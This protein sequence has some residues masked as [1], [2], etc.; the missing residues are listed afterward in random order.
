M[1]DILRIDWNEIYTQLNKREGKIRVYKLY[2]LINDPIKDVW[3]KLLPV[4][5]SI[6]P[7]KLGNKYSP[8]DTMIH[9]PDKISTPY[10][11]MDKDNFR[12]L[13]KVLYENPRSV[14]LPGKASEHI[15]WSQL[16]PLW[17]AAYKEYKN[18]GYNEWIR[19]DLIKFMVGPMYDEIQKIP[20]NFKFDKS[21]LDAF[22]DA[23]LIFGSNKTRAPLTSPN[24]KGFEL[25]EGFR[26]KT[27]STVAAMYLQIWLANRTL[28]HPNMIL[29]PFDWEKVPEPYD[30]EMLEVTAK[31]T[32][33]G[34][35]VD[36]EL[37]F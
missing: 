15:Q 3:E 29:D 6:E 30:L 10:G 17:L 9:I 31:K 28:R 22:R 8:R 33:L 2:N 16:I 26:V 20:D 23:A 37:P 32:K 34:R 14:L 19:D 13:I 5:A 11:L 4:L 24:R 1:T 36:D 21:K 35:Q 7:R 18:I 25:A 27:N 12:N